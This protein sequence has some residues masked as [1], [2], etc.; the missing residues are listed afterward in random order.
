MDSFWL[1]FVPDEAKFVLLFFSANRCRSIHEF[2][3]VHDPLQQW[4]LLLR[5][6]LDKAKFLPPFLGDPVAVACRGGG[7]EQS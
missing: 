7:R 4:V 3:A 5:F 1:V 6:V 2:A